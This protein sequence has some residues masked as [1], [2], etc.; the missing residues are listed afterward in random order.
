MDNT[1]GRVVRHNVN[2]SVV[3]I[4]CS[5]FCEV[6]APTICKYLLEHPAVSKRS[7]IYFVHVARASLRWTMC[8]GNV[9]WR[10]A[11][12][13]EGFPPRHRSEVLS[14]VCV[15]CVAGCLCVSCLPSCVGC[16]LLVNACA[17]AQKCGRSD[18]AVD[19][20]Q[21]ESWTWSIVRFL[22]VPR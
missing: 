16:L 19:S 21:S 10:H 15:R 17:G 14:I 8:I 18:G 20:N 3:G 5:L 6:D 1:A 11:D 12:Q 22:V 4:V 13:G 7:S 9:H 2:T